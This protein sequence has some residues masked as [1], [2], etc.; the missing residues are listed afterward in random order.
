MALLE[1]HLPPGSVYV[2]TLGVDASQQGRGHGS[3]LLKKVF[4][5]QA[6]RWHTVVLRTEQPKNV[7]FYLRNG[8]RLVDEQVIALS[9]LRVWAFS[10]PLR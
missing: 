3:A 2:S 5:L 4:A 9:G 1:P 10:R 6:E 7:P 8:F